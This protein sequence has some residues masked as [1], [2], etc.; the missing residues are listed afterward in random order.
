M[1]CFARILTLQEFNSIF[2]PILTTPLKADVGVNM[3]VSTAK[4][5]SFGVE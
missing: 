3:E 5:M 2:T 1:V 4:N